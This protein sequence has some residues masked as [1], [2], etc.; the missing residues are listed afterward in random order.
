LGPASGTSRSP[1]IKVTVEFGRAFANAAGFARHVVE[2]PAGAL[3]PALLAALG[4]LA[5]ALPCVDSGT[6]AVDLSAAHLSVNGQGVDPRHPERTA[7][8]EGDR[9]YLYGVLSGG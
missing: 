7:L 8:H 9:C 5:P 2:L 3:V 6:G 1:P 4:A